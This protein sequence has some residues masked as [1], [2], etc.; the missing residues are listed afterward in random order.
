MITILVLLSAAMVSIATIELGTTGPSPTAVR[1][2]LASGASAP[3]IMDN[4]IIELRTLRL[5][6]DGKGCKTEKV[7]GCVNQGARSRLVINRRRMV[8]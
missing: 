6:E 2:V 7:G 4:E 3:D 8:C 1:A 5:G